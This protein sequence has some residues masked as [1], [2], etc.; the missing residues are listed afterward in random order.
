[1]KPL[2]LVIAAVIIGHLFLSCHYV[3][4]LQANSDLSP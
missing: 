3:P 4:K 1:M 2:I